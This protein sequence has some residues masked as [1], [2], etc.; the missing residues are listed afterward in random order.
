MNIHEHKILWKLELY[1]EKQRWIPRKQFAQFRKLEI[2]DYK[3]NN[4]VGKYVLL[5]D[6]PILDKNLI[7]CENKLLDQDLVNQVYEKLNNQKDFIE[8]IKSKIFPEYF[9]IKSEFA[10]SLFTVITRIEFG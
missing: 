9:F 5:D 4:L 6:L 3:K 8:S 10:N 2:I 1:A 7:L